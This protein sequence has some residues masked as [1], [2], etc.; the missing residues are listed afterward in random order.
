[1]KRR[2][3]LLAA[4]ALSFIACSQRPDACSDRTRDTIERLFSYIKANFSPL[5]GLS[6]GEQ[7]VKDTAI[8]TMR[9][10]VGKTKIASDQDIK[11]ALV[12]AISEDIE[13]QSYIQSSG[14]MITT[15]EALISEIAGNATKRDDFLKNC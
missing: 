5:E 1:M 14:T 4:P 13:R 6:L 7:R 9:R 3:F 10:H 11:A 8:E 12:D 15:T 2:D